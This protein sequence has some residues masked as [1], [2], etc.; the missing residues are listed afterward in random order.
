MSDA[1][2]FHYFRW[3]SHPL[4]WGVRDSKHDCVIAL[5]DK[6][7]CRVIAGVLNGEDSSI[8]EGVLWTYPVSLD[9]HV[10]SGAPVWR[11]ETD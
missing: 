6:G 10:A 8:A 5:G 3:H 1:P 9:Q 7:I 11:P 2:R 4:G